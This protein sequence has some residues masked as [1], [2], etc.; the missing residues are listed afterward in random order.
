[1]ERGGGSR[2]QA[3]ARRERAFRAE[4]TRVRE[5]GA[6]GEAGRLRELFDFLAERGHA[7]GPATQAEIADAVF[8]QTGVEG[9]DATV[10]VYIHRLRKRLQDYYAAEGEGQR[11]ARLAL[12]AG[13]YALRLGDGD[14][15]PGEAVGAKSAAPKWWPYAAVVLAAVAL[16]FALGRLLPEPGDPPAANAV[17]EPFV[18]SERPIMVVVGDYYIYGEIDPVRPEEGRMIRDFRV[19]SPTDLARMQEV[20][21]ERYGNAEDFGLTYL[22]VSSA[23]AL[24]ELM[25]I[26]SRHPQPVGVMPA[27]ELDSETAR[28]FNIVYV[29]LLSGMRLLEDVTF[30]GSAFALGESYDEVID[31]R[32]G[33]RYVSEEARSLAS[34]VYYR[35]YGFLAVFREPGGALVGVLAGA[36]DTGLRGTARLAA[37]QRL[38]EGLSEVART[39]GGRGYEALFQVT[40]QQGADLSERLLV[41]RPRP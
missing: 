1:M 2:G 22:P 16:A 31:S 13:T 10:R 18:E 37:A 20:A 27:S 23:Y 25:P 40:G 17:W 35:D 21:P 36:R 19:N 15:G 24:R 38:P 39:N 30:T 8:G 12:P 14:E 32:A 41:A 6:I 26:L 7:A 33:R 3:N 34:P 9:D 29:G 4:V 11:G 5:S 28:R